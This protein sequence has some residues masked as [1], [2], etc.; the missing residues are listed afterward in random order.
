MDTQRHPGRTKAILLAFGCALALCTPGL[1]DKKKPVKG[2][3]P[4]RGFDSGAPM[5]LLYV[6][7]ATIPGN[8]RATDELLHFADRV[9]ATAIAI[10]ASPVGY[11]EPGALARYA[12]F[13]AEARHDGFLV[14]ALSGYPWF[15]VSPTAAAP[16]QPT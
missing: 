6:W 12:R 8:E 16:G 11:G 14:I 9:R 2:S 5:N 10:E 7:D 15:T 4:V 13:A 3:P 1:A